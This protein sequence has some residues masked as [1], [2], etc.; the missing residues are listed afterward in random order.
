MTSTMDEA[1]KL[2][3]SGCP[4]GSAVLADSQ[5]H[6]RGR[7]NRIWTSASP[8]NL[9]VSF[10]LRPKSFDQV[11]NINFAAPLA[12]AMA[13][14]SSGGVSDAKVKWPND[15]WVGSR[16]LAGILLNTMASGGTSQLTVNLGIGVNVNQD[17]SEVKEIAKGEATSLFLENGE[18]RV[19]REAF[20]ADL[21]QHLEDLISLQR[22]DLMQIY[23]KYDILLGKEIVV[24]PNKKE[25]PSTYYMAKAVEYSKEGYLV[26][27]DCKGGEKKILSA[28]EEALGQATSR[29]RQNN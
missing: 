10:I 13:A 23:Q 20:L 27:E 25:D 21:C 6:G 26:V 24:M 11:I 7:N 2:S 14:D 12:V 28:E 16:K 17:M 29:G 8:S 15:V 5:T 19:E 3:K 4:S 22:N 9:Y 1:D 18:K